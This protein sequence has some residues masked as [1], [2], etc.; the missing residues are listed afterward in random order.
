M[1]AGRLHWRADWPASSARQKALA[2][3]FENGTLTLTEA[4]TRKRALLHVVR[5]RA[6]LAA[7]Q[8]GRL[9]IE[10]ARLEEFEARLKKRNHTLKRALTD[11]R[12]LSGIG[13]AYSG[14]I[15]HRARLSPVELTSRLTAEET[16]R[17]F[18]ATRAVLAEWLERL[19]MKACGG[20]PEKVTAFHDEMAVH[21]RYGGAIAIRR[22][23]A[24]ATPTPRRT[25]A[26]AAR[27]RGGSL[28]TARCRG[29]SSRTG[30]GRSTSSRSSGH[31]RRLAAHHRARR[32]GR[33]LRSRRAAR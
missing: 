28:P 32:H 15:L 2:L 29:C 5:G 21:G 3:G 11:P 13:N 16:V 17:L 12:L 1:I 14:E 30:R 22:C 8:P 20:F 25:T 23:S 7:H 18:A 33:I 19:R 4:G 27:P 26:R 31:E 24:S 6:A 10:H 9:E